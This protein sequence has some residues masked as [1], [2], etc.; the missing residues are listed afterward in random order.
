MAEIKQLTVME[1]SKMMGMNQKT[2]RLGLQQGAFPWG[3]AIKTS[4]NRW[5]YFISKKRFEEIEGCSL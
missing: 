4:E 3:Y 5:V 2:V 1:V